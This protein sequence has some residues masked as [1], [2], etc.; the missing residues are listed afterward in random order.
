MGNKIRFSSSENTLEDRVYQKVVTLFSAKS[1]WLTKDNS[2]LLWV[3]DLQD[4]VVAGW[5]L[6]DELEELQSWTI[7]LPVPDKHFAYSV[8]RF[9]Q[10]SGL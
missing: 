9:S 4:P 3:V 8:N 10:V 2:I 5:F 7:P 6:D 1:S